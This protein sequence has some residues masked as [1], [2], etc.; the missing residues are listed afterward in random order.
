MNSW[1]FSPIVKINYFLLPTLNN[2]FR[3][4]SF[5]LFVYHPTTMKISINMKTWNAYKAHSICS[6]KN[7]LLS[8]DDTGR[9]HSKLLS[10]FCWFISHHRKWIVTQIYRGQDMRQKVRLRYLGLLSALALLKL[11]V[12]SQLIVYSS[13]SSKMISGR[14]TD[15][16]ISLG[17]ASIKNILQ[18]AAVK[19]FFCLQGR[20]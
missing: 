8:S 12:L 5:K 10:V 18:W 9:K 3:Y 11:R 6:A 15:I 7:P 14:K 13:T 17:D 16:L 1:I 19:L 20:T 2:T 4:I